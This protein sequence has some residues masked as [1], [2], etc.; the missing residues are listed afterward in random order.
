MTVRFD[1]DKI[2]ITYFPTYAGGKFL[3]NCL[4]LSCHATFQHAD[5]ALMDLQ[6]KDADASN[7]YN[8]KVERALDSIPEGEDKIKNWRGNEIYGCDKLFNWASYLPTTTNLSYA[9]KTLSNRDDTN[10]FIIAHNLES[11]KKIKNL[12]QNAKILKIVD[13]FPF[14]E[15]AYNKKTMDGNFK[16]D[17]NFIKSISKFERDRSKINVDYCIS[18]KNIFNEELFLEELKNLYNQL[19]Y[20]DFN[21]ELVRVFYRKYISIHL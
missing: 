7:Y 8:W 9:I 5:I 16:K 13:F 10:F 6:L 11:L 21:K 1:S 4:A 2:I 20:D 15:I 3:I 19:G 18:Y 12:F 14:I 17:K